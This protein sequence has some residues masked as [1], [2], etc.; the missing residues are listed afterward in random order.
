[1]T[2]N[3]FMDRAANEARSSHGKRSEQRVAKK[4]GA[5]LTPS[6]GALRSAKGDMRQKTGAIK[7]AQEAKSTIHDTMSLDLGWLVKIQHEALAINCSPALSI[8]FVTPEG[9]GRP[10]GDW[11]CMPL[12][13]YQELLETLGEQEHGS[14][15]V[16]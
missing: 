11:V 13:T 14:R 3:P 6:S 9:K 4:L 15:L 1:M 5:T 10:H 12:A 16:K 8:S 7:W 2:R